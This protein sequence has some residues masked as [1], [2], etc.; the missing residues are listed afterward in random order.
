MGLVRIRKISGRELLIAV[1]MGNGWFLCAEDF[2][3]VG[4]ELA[5]A[6]AGGYEALAFLLG[7]DGDDGVIEPLVEV[8]MLTG[9]AGAEGWEGFLGHD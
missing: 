3:V 9:E 4:I 6:E 8:G 5:A 7:T 2:G 1:V